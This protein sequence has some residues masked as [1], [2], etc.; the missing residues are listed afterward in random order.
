LLP[1]GTVFGIIASTTTPFCRRCDRSRLTADG[2]WFLCLYALIGT[3]LRKPLRS[4]ASREEIRS[5]ILSAWQR[6]NDRGAEERKSLGGRSVLVGV[7]QLRRD[8]HLEMH[9]RGGY[10]LSRPS[11]AL[12]HSTS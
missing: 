1:D 9:T 2:L 11:K 6:R 12:R 10:W 3:D 4:G 7:E 8:P 5:A